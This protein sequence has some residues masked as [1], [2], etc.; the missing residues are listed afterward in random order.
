M[1]SLRLMALVGLIFAAIE[2][3]A[4]Q[5]KITNQGTN[6][7]WVKPFWGAG[8][9]YLFEL[10]PGQSRNLDSGFASISLVRWVQEVPI[11]AG[12]A[13]PN[14]LNV[15][16]FDGGRAITLN[17]AELGVTLDILNDGSYKVQ[18]ML[19]PATT[20]TAQTINGF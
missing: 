20:A 13:M 12:Q 9:P 6:R 14:V 18:K 8:D 2:S 17:P 7:V 16:I 10:K 19:Q 1:K 5:L 15:K 4:A 11:T 3:T